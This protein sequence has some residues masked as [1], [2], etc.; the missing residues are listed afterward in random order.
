MRV[1]D[2]A[3]AEFAVYAIAVGEGGGEA[4]EHAHCFTLASSSGIQFC[5]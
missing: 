2:A 3:G 1:G 5:T 4:G